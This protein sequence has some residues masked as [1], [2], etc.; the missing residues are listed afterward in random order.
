VC[1]LGNKGRK[2]ISLCLTVH[3][4]RPVNAPISNMMRS[5]GIFSDE[6]PDVEEVLN[7]C[8]M[9][10]FKLMGSDESDEEEQART[11][12]VYDSDK[13]NPLTRVKE[14]EQW[15][16]FAVVHDKGDDVK[17]YALKDKSFLE[18]MDSGL[19]EMYVCVSELRYKRL[20]AKR[21]TTNFFEYIPLIAQCISLCRDML[22][23]QAH[24]D[25]RNPAYDFY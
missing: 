10:L 16:G 14:L 7:H 19:C 13:F 18:A 22:M 17:Y 20:L 4:M 9:K 2:W 12:C 24:D 11:D 8:L 25:E 1:K 3:K 23:L 5:D 6:E 21:S 15:N